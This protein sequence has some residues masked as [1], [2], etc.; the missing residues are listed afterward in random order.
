MININ[1]IK[2]GKWIYTHGHTTLSASGVSFGIP[3]DP[4]NVDTDEDPEHVSLIIVSHANIVSIF[5]TWRFYL[6]IF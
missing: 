5:I 6:Y 4:Y 1:N 2:Y 3:S